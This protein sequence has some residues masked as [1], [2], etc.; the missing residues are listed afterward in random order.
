MSYLRRALPAALLLLLILPAA[1]LADSA[2]STLALSPGQTW[3][4]LL[5]AVTPLVSYALNK[6]APWADER[7]KG[8]VHVVLAA[9]VGALYKLVSTGGL[10]FSRAATWQ[11]I[12]T[13]VLAALVAHKIFYAPSGLNVTFGAGQ[14]ATRR[15][16]ARRG[17]PR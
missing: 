6:Y 10:D 1:A 17:N 2:Q 4:A 16:A 12:G 13:A 3:V 8:I 11:Y 14:N 7:V 15:A 5:G 9:V